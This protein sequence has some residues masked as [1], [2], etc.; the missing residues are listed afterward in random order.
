M[1]VRK[2]IK[3]DKE[4]IKR[5][6]N[7]ARLNLTEKEIEE[8][9]PQFKDILNVFS[10]ISEV[11]TDNV[12]VTN[13]IRMNL[14]KWSPS[15]GEINYKAYGLCTLEFH[16]ELYGTLHERFISSSSDEN[17]A[18]RRS[19]LKVFD[20]EILAGNDMN[21]QAKNWSE[22]R[23][24]VQQ[25]SYKVTLSTFVRNKMHHPESSQTDTYTPTDFDDSIRHLLSLL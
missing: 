20:L 2:T 1:A 24:T 6:A 5:V 14:L 16:D 3:I 17:E 22:L 9:I 8:F 15:W 13:S 19:Y 11:N 4:L 12:K 25:P 18:K 7:N 23:G 10:K 21:K